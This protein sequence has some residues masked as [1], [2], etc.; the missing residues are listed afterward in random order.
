[1]A[2]SPS[3]AVYLDHAAT[4]PPSAE[5]VAAVH[6]GLTGYF[7]NPSAAHGAGVRVRR[8]LE[9]ERESIARFC[10]IEPR[11][12]VFTSG[13]TEANQL[14]VFGAPRRRRT[15]RLLTSNAEHPSLRA[16]TRGATDLEVHELPIDS[17]GTIP[18][19]TF[20]A[21][22]DD[23][24]ALVAVFEGHNEIGSR[25]PIEALSRL[26]RERAPR[27][28][29]HIDS[30]Q[31][32]GKFGP[33]PLHCVDSA[34]IS[35]H[36]VRGPKGIGALLLADPDRELRA[37]IVG[38]GQESGRRSGT[39]NVPGV[40]G[41]G[42]AVRELGGVSAE[43]RCRRIELRDLLR[44]AVRDRVPAARILGDPQAALPHIVAVCIPG[45]LAKPALHHLEERGVIA[46]AGAAC[47]ARKDRVSHAF[48]ALGLSI[49]EARSTL[50]F[51]LGRTTTRDDIVWAVNAL[52]DTVAQLRAEPAGR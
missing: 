52:V 47:Q 9:E 16:A 37:Q 51:S 45:L 3:K 12:V 5:V 50:R 17:G 11:G 25:Q 14:A 18:L 4:T 10:G 20:E 40:L 31:A 15:R 42:Q 43:E 27:A 7:A 21:A 26:V 6:L 2:S 30:V 48:T 44:D 23:D 39:E 24:V 33:P 13:G 35:A 22:L 32:F 49:E 36:K 34:A 19:D 29:I 1:M 46:A 41:F 28:W 8:R 38:G